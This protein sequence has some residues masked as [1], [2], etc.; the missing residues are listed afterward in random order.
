MISHENLKVSEL[1]EIAKSQEPKVKINTIINK[2]EMNSHRVKDLR[3]IAKSRGLKGWYRLRKSD[4][5]SFIK[6]SENQQRE[7]EER[8]QREQ[9]QNEE[10]QIE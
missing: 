8:E 10:I 6:E 2:G 7:L 9:Q 3:E 4:L 1:Q 5:I